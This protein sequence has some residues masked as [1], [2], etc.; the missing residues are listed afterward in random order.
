MVT[1]TR[2]PLPTQR[3]G[4]A[5]RFNAPLRDRSSRLGAINLA[6]RDLMGRSAQVPA[7]WR[8]PAPTSRSSPRQTYAGSWIRRPTAAEVRK[9]FPP[10]HLP[11]HLPLK[12]CQAVP[13]PRPYLRS[14]Q[15][16]RAPRAIAAATWPRYANRGAVPSNPS[17]ESG[18]TEACRLARVGASR[19]IVAN[20]CKPAHLYASAQLQR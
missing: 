8:L 4:S 18:H 10:G 12:L 16:S 9:V 6:S 7:P 15:S 17:L 3:V 2:R 14:R 20:P 1:N 19:I 13:F 5:A 11:K